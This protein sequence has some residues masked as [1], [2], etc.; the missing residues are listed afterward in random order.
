M[1]MVFRADLVLDNQ[2]GECFCGRM[3]LLSQQSLI[4]YGSLSRVKLCEISPI[5]VGISLVSSLF[6]SFLG[7]HIVG[8]SSYLS[9]IE[10]SLLPGVLLLWLMV[11]W[12]LVVG[13]VL[14]LYQ[15]ELG[16]SWWGIL[17]VWLVVAF[18]NGLHLLQKEASLMMSD[19]YM[20]TSWYTWCKKPANLLTDH[21]NGNKTKERNE[22]KKQVCT[23]IRTMFIITVSWMFSAWLTMYVRGVIRK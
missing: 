15:L 18:C 8:I 11:F 14:Y 20:E 19:S 2:L 5:F 17:H 21:N 23:T 7:C 1:Y 10:G 9:L 6:R 4:T 12:V 16:S 13:V 3:I 22:K